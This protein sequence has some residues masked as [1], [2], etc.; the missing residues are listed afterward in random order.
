MDLARIAAV[1]A[2][3]FGVVYHRYG[4]WNVHRSVDV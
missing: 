4:L 3:R 2:D 1:V